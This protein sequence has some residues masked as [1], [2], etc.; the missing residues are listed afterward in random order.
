MKD[1]NK[2]FSPEKL[3]QK[4]RLLFLLNDT[5]TYGFALAM[6]RI[7]SLITFPLLA[8]HF[9]VSEYGK[10]DFFLILMS[11]LNAFV[12]FGQD[13]AVARYFYE[14]KTIQNRKQLISQSLIIQLLF[15]TICLLFFYFFSEF[16]VNKFINYEKN[17]IYLQII[18]IQIPL[19][20]LINFSQNLLKWTFKRSKFMIM[21]LGFACIQAIS[22]I[23]GIYFFELNLKLVLLIYLFSHFI[24]SI[25]GIMFIKH[26]LTFN[27][28]KNFLKKL[29]PFGVPFGIICVLDSFIPVLERNI[30]LIYLGPEN[31]GLFSAGAKVASIIAILIGSFQMAWEPFSTSLH[32]EK[33]AYI[34]YNYVFKTFCFF[35]CLFFLFIELVSEYLLIFL[36]SKKYVV[37]SS[38]ILPIAAVIGVKGI[39]GITEIGINLSKKSY[40]YLYS[41]VIFIIVAIT[42]M[43]FLIPKLE[44]MGVVISLLIAEIVRSILSSL[45]AQKIYYLDWEYKPVIIML[46]ITFLTIIFGRFY[47]EESAIFIKIIFFSISSLSLFL[48]YIKVISSKIKFSFFKNNL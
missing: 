27:F 8:R 6:S 19:L 22:I 24:F 14:Y 29:I 32:R 9:S 17:K 48:L 38:L 26:W 2:I 15:C 34:T 28:N 36:A 7:F 45:I 16:F 41:H 5:F 30:I 47:F 43:Y 42:S 12:I 44:L 20:L 10:L 35:I 13:S 46:T 39:S 11:F 23:I 21:S 40:F 18:M 25:I 37:A 33:N 31:L 1:D 4:E 3:F